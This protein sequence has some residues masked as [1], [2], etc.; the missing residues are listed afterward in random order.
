MN[1]YIYFSANFTTAGARLQRNPLFDTMRLIMTPK[2]RRGSPYMVLVLA[3]L[4][5]FVLEVPCRAEHQHG[6]YTYRVPLTETDWWWLLSLLHSCAF[7]PCILLLY[8]SY[9]YI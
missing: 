3:Q 4:F 5:S 8:F 6:F 1:I 9:G 7:M 2:A